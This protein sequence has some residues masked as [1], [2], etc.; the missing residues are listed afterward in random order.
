MKAVFILLGLLIAVQSN[1]VDWNYFGASM[2][3]GNRVDVFYKDD[4]TKLP[5]GNLQVW[6]KGIRTADML[7]FDKDKVAVMHVAH[8]VASYYVPPVA[9]VSTAD[10]TQDQL[11]NV[12]VDEEYANNP[13]HTNLTAVSI[14]F[15]LDCSSKQ[16]R[17]LSLRSRKPQKV[18]NGEGQWEHVV[19]ETNME[20]LMK[21]ACANPPIKGG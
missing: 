19:P 10:F 1:A 11:L 7:G 14:L 21:I 3:D 6:T 13:L 20:T 9:I 15:E 12:L 5:N 8:K 4:I 17:T 18:W 2:I 16:S